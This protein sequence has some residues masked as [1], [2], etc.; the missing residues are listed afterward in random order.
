VDLVGVK[1]AEGRNIP[2]GVDRLW[3]GAFW[4][5]I[6]Y[7]SI[8]PGGPDDF[9]GAFARAICR[10]FGNNLPHFTA[11]AR[12]DSLDNLHTAGQRKMA[13]KLLRLLRIRLCRHER[14][15]LAFAHEGFLYFCGFLPDSG[16][17]PG[18]DGLADRLRQIVAELRQK[19]GILVTFGLCSRLA[20][21]PQSRPD[22]GFCQSARYAVVALRIQLSKE[23]GQVRIYNEPARDD[24]GV[25]PAKLVD[26]L[27]LVVQTGRMNK[28]LG[29]CTELSDYL[30]GHIYI[31]LINLR[32]LLQTLLVSMA[33]AAQTAG[34]EAKIIH[35]LNRK[36]LTLLMAPYDYTQLRQTL[37]E[38]VTAFTAEVAKVRL[39]E[40][41]HPAIQAA[42]D[43]IQQHI[44][45]PL[46][47][48]VIAEAV[49]L[50]ASYL[51][52]LFHTYRGNTIT[53]FINHERVEAAK[54]LLN[55]PGMSVAEVAFAAG[56]GSLQHFNRVFRATL[57]CTPTQYRNQKYVQND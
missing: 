3:I 12:I 51:S 8:S 5:H 33:L 4:H 7:P 43:Y 45:E 22:T 42:E 21:A 26:W 34:V 44:G 18:I 47:L 53:N 9:G 40:Q 11:A 50:S 16:S 25:I 38:A 54:N 23:K 31:P 13:A 27:R 29:V 24:S 56:F 30:F 35:T 32:V 55:D 15:L 52:Q 41:E 1:E 57:G 49:G 14:K 6:L 36:Y 46:S 37:L 48:K 10:I 20:V 2:R 17:G 19:E 28:V 39:H